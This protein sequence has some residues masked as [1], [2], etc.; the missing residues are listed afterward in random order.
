MGIKKVVKK[1]AG[2]PVKVAK[3]AFAEL[4]YRNTETKKL[5]KY[6]ARP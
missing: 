5:M 2:V 3:R 4:K 6:G 1:V